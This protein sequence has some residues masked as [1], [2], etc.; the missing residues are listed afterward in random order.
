MNNTQIISALRV[1]AKACS[2][3]EAFVAWCVHCIFVGSDM[4][5]LFV[6]LFGKQ[7]HDMIQV[8][9]LLKG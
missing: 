1:Q 9:T 6:E 7:G 5:T 4:H 8:Y 2:T 3:A